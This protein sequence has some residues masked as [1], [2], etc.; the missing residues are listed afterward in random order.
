M[1]TVVVAYRI[2][3]TFDWSAAKDTAWNRPSLVRVKI[4]KFRLA[5]YEM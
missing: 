5:K 3:K 4:N 1:L 2:E